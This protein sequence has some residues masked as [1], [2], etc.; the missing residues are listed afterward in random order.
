MSSAPRF[1]R[2]GPRPLAKLAAGA[3]IGADPIDGDDLDVGRRH[4]DLLK[5]SSNVGLL[6]AGAEF[7]EADTLVLRIRIRKIIDRREL[8]RDE[9]GAGFRSRVQPLS[10]SRDLRGRRRSSR[11]LLKPNTPVI[12]SPSAAETEIGLVR[13]HGNPRGGDR[14][15]SGW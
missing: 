5:I 15:V 1:D 9:P 14:N 12:A 10:L 13:A 3:G 8:R 7:E 4:P 11:W 6:H 2:Q